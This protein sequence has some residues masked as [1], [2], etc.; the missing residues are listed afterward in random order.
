M[1]RDAL[2]VAS[3]LLLAGCFKTTGVNRYQPNLYSVDQEVG[4]GREMSKAIEQEMTIVRHHQLTQL[5][6]QIGDR[7]QR[8]A[9]EPEFRDYPFTFKV[10][11]SSEVNAFSLPGGPIYVNLGLVELAD[12][13]EELAGVIAHEMSHVAARHATERVTTMQLS[14]LA[15]MAVLTT[16]GGG[17]YLAMEGGRLGYVLGILKYSRGMESEADEMAVRT[18]A[19]AGY[20][21]MGMVVMFEKLAAQR[22][23]EPVL[24]ERLMA[25]HPMP[26]DRVAAVKALIVAQGAV[27]ATEDRTRSV[28]AKVKVPFE[29]D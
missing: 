27:A 3:A 11:D 19:R 9:V 17:P 5:V 4:L 13:E 29:K 26:D 10:V 18:M 21:P 14:Q 28:F 1:R 22:L 20:D 2:L 6:Q 12:D 23:T 8:A 24:L 15:L 25:S 16:V 7:L